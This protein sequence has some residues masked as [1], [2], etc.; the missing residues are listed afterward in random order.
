M[1]GRYCRV[2]D[3][4]SDLSYKCHRCGKP[5]HGDGDASGA[6]SLRP[7][8]GEPTS[9]LGIRVPDS[10]LEE[11]D[12]TIDYQN[13]FESRSD[14]IR[15][16]IRD[17]V[18]TYQPPWRNEATLRELYHDER[19]TISDVADELGCANSTV[20]RWMDHHEIE[21]RSPND[22]EDGSI[23][24]RKEGE[25]DDPE[26]LE[27]LYHE[28]DLTCSEIAQDVFDGSVSRETIRTRLNDFDIIGPEDQR[29]ST[30]HQLLEISSPD[31][32]GSRS[33]AEAGDLDGSSESETNPTRK[34]TIA[35]DGSG[36][37]P[38]TQQFQTE[39]T[40]AERGLEGA[41]A[42]CTDPAESH[43]LLAAYR[44]LMSV[45]FRDHDGGRSTAG[46]GM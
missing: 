19:L 29:K 21:R 16:A 39:I 11:L 43:E 33:A 31:D 22:Y 1:S 28:E 30:A 44:R 5:F 10:L 41:I 3:A 34:E 15:E 4:E 25:W 6:Q 38:T 46:G 27:R 40:R 12:V 8:G 35:T 2:C 13:Q 37:I 36:S 45:R 32:I 14:G 42:A 24:T 17:F 7:D 9:N 23:G 20:S 18:D 26:A